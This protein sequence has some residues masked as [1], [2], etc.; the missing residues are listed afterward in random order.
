MTMTGLSINIVV[1][2]E[3]MEDKVVFI[4]SN[5]ELGVSDFGDTLEEAIENFKK[6]ANLYL[7]SYPEK[8]KRLIKQEEPV[9]VS[10]ILI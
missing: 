1:R 10:R 8:R 6:S 4:V 5:E 7:D 9:F 3:Q 2:E